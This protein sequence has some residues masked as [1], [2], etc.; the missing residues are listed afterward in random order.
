LR[1][2]QGIA[3]YRALGR[4][5]G[6][7]FEVHGEIAIAGLGAPVRPQAGRLRLEG[8]NVA[9]LARLWEVGPLIGTVDAELLFHLDGDDYFPLGQ[10]RVVITDLGYGDQ[11]LVSQ[12]QGD[13]VVNRKE[14]MV[15]DVTAAIGQ[16]TVTGKMVMNLKEP[17]R[18]WFQISLDNAEAGELLQ[19]WPAVAQHV[20]GTV[21]LRLRGKIGREW[22][23]AAD[24]VL[25]RGK[26]LGLD[27]SEWRVP[28]RW[29]IV[30]A[31]GHGRFEVQDSSAQVAQ[32]RVTTQFS[33]G[34]NN[35]LR[36]HGQSQFTGVDLRQALPSAKLGNGKATGR[37]EFAS[38]RY[39]SVDDLT[40][41]L[42][43]TLQQTQALDYPVLR[44]VGPL[45]GLKATTTFQ[46]GEVRAR[47]AQGVVRVERLAFQEGPLQ[48]YADGNVTLA[49]RVNLDMTAN[50]GKLGNMA[51]ALGWRVP[52]TGTIA[53]D[54]LVRAT[55]ALSPQ[56]VHLHI[57]GTFRE[58]T[59]QVAPLP[60]LTEQ[61]L[62]FFA[63]MR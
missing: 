35:G 51:A 37:L 59:I 56:L 45:L 20:Q 15:R 57:R 29:T 6:G 14:L 30:P 22:T 5:L 9:Q 52:A 7:G 8:I 16:G 62:R 61:A 1:L 27:V 50:T 17:E 41:T 39:Q 49:G 54:M 19:S 4:S 46:G 28:L 43:A 21:D 13:V 34:W 42:T 44:Q 10:G 26:V 25:A 58:P 3:S 47:L 63:G 24:I 38:E 2:R 48:L 40:A 32:G 11:A 33:A 12:L 60:L 31:D 53:Q 55:T 36:F 23:G 18:S